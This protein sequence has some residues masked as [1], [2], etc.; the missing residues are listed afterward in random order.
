MDE[1]VLQNASLRCGCIAPLPPKLSHVPYRRIAGGREQDH[2]RFVV[3]SVDPAPPQPT[4]GVSS[5]DLGRS[6]LRT[7]FFRDRRPRSARGPDPVA[8]VPRS[9]VAASG[10]IVRRQRDEPLTFGC[11][12]LQKTHL[13]FVRC[14]TNFCIATSTSPARPVVALLGRFLPRLG[15]FGLPNGPFS[16]SGRSVVSIPPVAGIGLP[17]APEGTRRGLVARSSRAWSTGNDRI[18]RWAAGRIGTR[19]IAAAPTGG[20]EIYCIATHIGGREA[21]VSTR[22]VHALL[23]RFLPRLDG[24]PQGGRFF[25]CASRRAPWW[26]ARWHRPRQGTHSAAARSAMRE[27]SSKNNRAHKCSRSLRNPSKLAVGVSE[28][29]SM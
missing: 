8:R 1:A 24:R 4:L 7:A 13:Q 25:L 15:P 3:A 14:T 2:F 26:A 6:S 27:G 18:G 22:A 23:G 20:L 21:L 29:S 28:L 19:R 16:L 5:L 9:A 11:P 12:A 10:V 17:Y